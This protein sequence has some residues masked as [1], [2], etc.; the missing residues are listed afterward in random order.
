MPVYRGATPRAVTGV[1]PIRNDRDTLQQI[2]ALVAKL[3]LPRIK[4][5]ADSIVQ[6]LMVV[7]RSMH[8]LECC[9]RM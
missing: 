8:V 6:D 4:R 9:V 7:A 5:R 2:V 3:R 1:I